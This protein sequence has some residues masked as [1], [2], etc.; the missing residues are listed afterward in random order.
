MNFSGPQKLIHKTKNKFTKMNIS[1][2]VPQISQNILLHVRTI[3]FTLKM[4]AARFSE[5][6]DMNTT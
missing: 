1:E 6:T 4:E 5:T 2:N 3:H